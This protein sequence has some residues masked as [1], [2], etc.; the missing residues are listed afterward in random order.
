MHSCN[1]YNVYSFYNDK[2]PKLLGLPRALYTSSYLLLMCEECITA[3]MHAYGPPCVS[4]A[5]IITQVNKNYNMQ[6]ISDG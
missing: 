2:L 4:Q 1:V 6:I 3:C 5:T